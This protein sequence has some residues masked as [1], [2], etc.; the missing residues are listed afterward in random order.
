M[1]T[2]GRKDK[3]TH[4]LHTRYY[5]NA[6]TWLLGAMVGLPRVTA[7]VL[8][9]HGLS[10]SESRTTWLWLLP[11]L[12]LGLVF[13]LSSRN[14]SSMRWIHIIHLLRTLGACRYLHSQTHS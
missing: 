1:K 11:W 5:N 7:L 8:L 14:D 12:K 3:E 10:L 6:E 2:T 13:T 9:L 4:H